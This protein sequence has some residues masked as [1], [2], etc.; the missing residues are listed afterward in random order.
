MDVVSGLEVSIKRLLPRSQ[1]FSDFTDFYFGDDRTDFVESSCM[2]IA[3][4]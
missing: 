4:H 3:M 1:A 2:A